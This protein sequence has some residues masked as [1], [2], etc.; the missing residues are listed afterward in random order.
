MALQTDLLKLIKKNVIKRA[1]NISQQYFMKTEVSEEKT[2]SRSYI[3]P[4]WLG[5]VSLA[6]SPPREGPHSHSLASTDM[7]L[8]PF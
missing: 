5:S 6:Q 1:T 2:N 3:K 4:N 7:D 8:G